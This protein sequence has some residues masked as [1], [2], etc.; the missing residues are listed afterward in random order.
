MR[1]FI[2]R[3]SADYSPVL[4]DGH[5]AAASPVGRKIGTP[6]AKAPPGGRRGLTKDVGSGD[7]LWSAERLP[8]RASFDSSSPRRALAVGIDE[9]R[10]SL[11]K[12]P[13][14]LP[15]PL[16]LPT[17]DA[18]EPPPMHD[19][20]AG[21]EWANSTPRT[22]PT[23]SG[24][25]PSRRAEPASHGDGAGVGGLVLDEPVGLTRRLEVDDDFST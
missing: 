25:L 1:E 11:S 20:F 15:P 14:G 5:P 24:S 3:L 17:L 22:H 4:P 10:A 12:V 18:H 2:R 23:P 9:R 7:L 6:A 8:A 21:R 13:D 16:P 19:P